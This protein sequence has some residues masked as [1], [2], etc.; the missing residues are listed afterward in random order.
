M[1]GNVQ[2][3][4]LANNKRVLGSSW[5]PGPGWDIHLGR[6]LKFP[7]WNCCEGTLLWPGTP[8]ELGLWT[9]HS[10]YQ[11]CHSATLSAAREAG[12]LCP[13]PLSEFLFILSLCHELVF[14]VQGR[15]PHHARPLSCGCA[16]GKQVSCDF[17][18]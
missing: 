18:L 17:L 10:G 3:K 16:L 15:P 12:P 11:C 13:L 4:K 5:Y 9:V 14:Q 1:F 7:V 6:V 2:I 8:S